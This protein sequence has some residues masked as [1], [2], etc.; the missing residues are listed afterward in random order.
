MKSFPVYK[1]SNKDAKILLVSKP[2][3]FKQFLKITYFHNN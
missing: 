3:E 1:M 2:V